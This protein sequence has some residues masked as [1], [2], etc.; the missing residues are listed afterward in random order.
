[1]PLYTTALLLLTQVACGNNAD[2]TAS[3]RSRESAIAGAEYA[4]DMVP[5]VAPSPAPQAA[6][7]AAKMRTAGG[8]ASQAQYTA[9]RAPAST[10]MRTG[11]A[12]IEV[13]SLEPAITA[14]RNVALQT[15]ANIANTMISAGTNNIRNATIELRVPAQRFDAAIDALAAIGTVQSVDVQAI[16][17]GEEF[18]D[19]E[20]RLA[21][22]KRLEARLLQLLETRTGRLEDVLNVERELARVR[23]E[24]ERIDGRLR[25]LREHV[26][27]STLVVA[28]HEPAPLTGTPG[29]NV[30]LDAL[31]AALR[32]LVG[33]IGFAIASLGFVVPIGGLAWIVWQWRRRRGAPR[34][35]VGTA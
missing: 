28:M 14:V 18:V 4:T 7:A 19:L 11:S 22:S 17:V 15:G 32:N 29:S 13:D 31:H 8:G 25:Y 10:T 33:V 34:T 26:A 5:A 9:Y 27:L 12:R 23:E 20:A 16:D 21:N 24:I 2:D 6:A 3:T 35:A 1:M 30:L